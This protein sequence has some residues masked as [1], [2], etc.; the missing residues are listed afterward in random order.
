MVDFLSNVMEGMRCFG[1]P[2]RDTVCHT[3]HPFSGSFQ[4]HLFYLASQQLTEFFNS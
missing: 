3:T 4:N 1:G 2:S